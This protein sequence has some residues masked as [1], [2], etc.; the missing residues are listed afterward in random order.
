MGAKCKTRGRSWRKT[1]FTKKK[2]KKKRR[3]AGELENGVISS[4]FDS[5]TDLL[6]MSSICDS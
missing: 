3:I 2:E 5:L 4:I 6:I 1:Y